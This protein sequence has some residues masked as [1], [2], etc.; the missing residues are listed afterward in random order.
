MGYHPSQYLVEFFFFFFSVSKFGLRLS[1]RLKQSDVVK[2]EIF[3]LT[4]IILGTLQNN[5]KLYFLYI[6]YLT[7][8]VSTNYFKG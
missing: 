1:V 4:I 5:F 8:R 6:D 3:T 2:E 7:D